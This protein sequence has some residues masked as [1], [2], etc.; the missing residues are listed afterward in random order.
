MESEGYCSVCSEGREK[1]QHSR[2]KATKY[3]V[4]LKHK[5]CT[6]ITFHYIVMTCYDSVYHRAC[7]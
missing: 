4:V 7:V 2:N 6:F 1:F 3:I 5:F